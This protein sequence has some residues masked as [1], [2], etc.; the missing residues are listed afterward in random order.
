M[1][2]SEGT[3]TV[4]DRRNG[5]IFDEQVYGEE[6]LRWVYESRLGRFL[7][8]TILSQPWVSAVMGA[9]HDSVLSS[10]KIHS[11]TKR[12]GIRMEEFEAGPFKSFNE[13]FI[14]R[15]VAGSRPFAP[16]PALAAFAEGRYFAWEKTNESTAVPVKNAL[17]S[18]KALLG[19]AVSD[20]EAGRFSGGP[21]LLA[22][23]C[24]TDYHR[25][26]FPDSGRWIS[27]RRISGRLH[28]VNPV[29]LAQRPRTFLDNERQV[30]LLDCDSLGLVA[31]IEVGALGVGKIV[32]SRVSAGRFERGEEKGYFLFGGSTV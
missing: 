24:P 27:C 11:F 26:H 14:R 29:A 30:S 1:S 22:R 5:Q 9:Y 31:Y 6:A 8:T 23:L 25:F 12:Y 3:I 18:P 15:F 21:L 10:G 7:E 13:F 28:S 16:A 19:D 4:H 32:Q 17:L 2:K 20:E